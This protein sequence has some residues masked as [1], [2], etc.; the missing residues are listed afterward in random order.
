MEY[1]PFKLTIGLKNGKE[2]DVSMYE[3]KTGFHYTTGFWHAWIEGAPGYWELLINE[4][5]RNDNKEKAEFYAS[6]PCRAK[7]EF[8]MAEIFFKWSQ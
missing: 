5:C 6:H 3:A 8:L 2:V 4:E 1:N 7:L